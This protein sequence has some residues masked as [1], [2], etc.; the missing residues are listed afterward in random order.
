MDPDPED[1]K[2]LDS[3]SLQKYWRSFSKYFNGR[4]AMEK[5]FVLEGLKRKVV[6]RVLARMGLS[7]NGSPGGGVDSEERVLVGVRHW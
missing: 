5:V 3:E 4:D 1:P 7:V 6:W 2:N